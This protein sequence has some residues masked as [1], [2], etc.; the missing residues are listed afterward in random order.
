MLQHFHAGDDIE[1]TGLFIGQ[2]FGGNAAVVKVGH[3]RLHGVQLRH[4]QGFVGQVDAQHVGTPS[5]HGFGQDATTAAHIDHV[6]ALD[7][8]ELIDP[9]QA[10]R[11]DLVQG[12][13]FTLWIPPLVGQVTE[14]GE[15]LG[16]SIDHERDAT[17][18]T[19]IFA[20]VSTF[21]APFLI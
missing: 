5:G 17:Q 8:C 12:A 19:E 21:L 14:F 1:L 4:F 10:Q 9:V 18:M 2:G 13:K 11:V 16:V 7:G 15:F 3:A 6:L 20:C